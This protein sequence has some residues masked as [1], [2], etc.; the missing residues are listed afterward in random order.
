MRLEIA[1]DITERKHLEL[2]LRQSEERFRLAFENAHSAMC[3]VDLQGRL[4][5]VNDRMSAIF[6]YRRQELEG[7]TVNDLAYPEDR[8]VSPDYMAK[9]IQG[10]VDRITFDKRYR[11]RDGPLIYGQVASSLVRD[12]Q[13]QPLYF[14]AQVEDVT[15]WRQAEEQL[16]A[17]EQRFRLVADHALDNIWTMGPDYRLRDISP[18]IQSL[19]GY[20]M[21]EYLSLTLDRMLMPVSL[22]VARDYFTRLDERRAA[23]LPLVDFPFRGE[24][25]L[26]TQPG[27]GPRSS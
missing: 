7:M 23:G 14:I 2:R 3:L 5:Q 9:A 1:T 4:M 15:A 11:H 26:R 6:G 17:S 16:R 13:G 21:E 10:L 22:G 18:S 24:I 20:S 25:E 19:V 12:H 27:S 8:S